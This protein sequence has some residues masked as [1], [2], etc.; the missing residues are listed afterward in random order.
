MQPSGQDASLNLR[1]VFK[2]RENPYEGAELATSRRVVSAMLGLSAILTLAFLPIDPPT[3]ALGAWGWLCAACLG[4]LSAVGVLWIRDRSRPAG[5]N[6]LLGFAY[7]GMAGVAL[8]EWLAGGGGSAYGALFLAWLG[9]GVVHPPRRAFPYLLAMIGAVAAPALYSSG[10]DERVVADALLLLAVG[11][12][13][14]IY[15]HHVRRQRVHAKRAAEEAEAL[16]RVDALTKLGNRRAFDE[17]L[18]VDVARAQREDARLSVGMIDLDGLKKINDGWGH[19]EGDR[20]LAELGR[21]LADSVR[22]SDRCFR[23]A[24]DEF[25]VLLPGTDR[26][27]ALTVLERVAERV[28]QTC[29]HP[30]GDPLEISYG[31]G[32]LVPAKSAEELVAIADE[33]LMAQKAGKRG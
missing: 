7:A 3:D 31:A 9:A 32:Q 19:L 2:R 27:T 5:F 28:R 6:L 16:A 10:G 24:G 25:S 22:V 12:V 23:W 4:L 1:S 13:M 17:A 26:E 29:R 14:V 30:N 21:A 11:A 33:E 8:L 18:T 15:L 20:C